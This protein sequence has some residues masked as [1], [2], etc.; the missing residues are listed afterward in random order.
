MLTP[1]WYTSPQQQPTF[2]P[3][4]TSLSYCQICQR[5]T[6]G[7]G[8][9]AGK[10]IRQ[11]K[12]NVAS[13]SSLVEHCGCRMRG[14]MLQQ[15][16]CTCRD[17]A[18]GEQKPG[19]AMSAGTASPRTKGLW[20]LDGQLA[21]CFPECLHVAFCLHVPV[22]NTTSGTAIYMATSNPPGTT[23]YMETSLGAE[24]KTSHSERFNETR[25]CGERRVPRGSAGL[26]ASGR[27]ASAPSKRPKSHKG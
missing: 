6:R 9:G 2:A 12:P 27:G 11:W 15:R 19:L 21:T 17:G 26:R 25:P 5:V 18:F 4:L 23:P 24:V 3:N 7:E 13:F 20:E 14:P 22:P 1:L 10:W 8:S 16:F